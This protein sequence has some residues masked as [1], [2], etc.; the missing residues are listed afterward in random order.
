MKLFPVPRSRSGPILS[1]HNGKKGYTKELETN[2]IDNDDHDDDDDVA[3][4]NERR[5]K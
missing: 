5:L 2:N 1:S 4:K 3:I